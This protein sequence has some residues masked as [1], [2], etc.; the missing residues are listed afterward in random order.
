MI[1]V[2]ILALPVLL[3]FVASF[4]IGIVMI[5][6]GL[7][8]MRLQSHGW[9]MTA[10][11]LALLPCS[12]VGILGLVVGIWSLVVLNR[13]NVKEAFDSH[14]PGR[15]LAHPFRTAPHT[16]TRG[17]GL[18]FLTAALLLVPLVMLFYWFGSAASPLGGNQGVL[19]IDCNAEIRNPVVLVQ[20]DGRQ[21]TVI[22]VGTRPSA[23]LDPG[24][25]QLL[26]QSGSISDPPGMPPGEMRLSASTVT[27]APGTRRLVSLS[28][29]R[30][31][32]EKTDA[33]LHG[34]PVQDSRPS[35]GWIMG[36]KGPTLTE[37]ATRWLNLKPAQVEE[38][39]KI[40]AASYQ[41]F[42]T[43]EAQN[44]ERKTDDTGH[45]VITIKAFPTGLAKLED[46]LWS[47][48][49]KIL[50]T[51]QQSVARL[52]L[53]LDPLEL[54]HGMTL[55][56]SVRPGFF[57]WGRDGARIELWRVGSW[58]HWKVQTRGNVDASRAPQL[59][60]EYRRFWTPPGAQE[61]HQ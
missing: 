59:P 14:N 48:L 28:V 20:R 60:E 39:N 55:S 50:N 8:M 21:V 22:D 1:S 3:A 41:E 42:L 12:P 52:N 9:A 36:P 2:L 31:P 10:S 32:V 47:Q 7:K 27:I 45:V 17:R 23:R 6:G 40:L 54:R 18:L 38:V 29:H 16:H 33:L 25:Y 56:D 37:D 30:R 51:Q 15:P 34:E 43:L 35:T 24:V 4:G 11:I 19:Q 5:I 44:T 49:D 13:R 61:D 58:S 26:L 57:G 46:Q 53:K